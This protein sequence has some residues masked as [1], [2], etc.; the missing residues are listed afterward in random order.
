VRGHALVFA[1][2][3]AIAFACPVNAQQRTFG[4]YPCKHECDLHVAGYEWAKVRGID[5]KRLCI[6]GS[7]RSFVEGCFAYVHNPFRNA[8]KDDEG[9]PVGVSVVPP[10]GK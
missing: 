2:G 8:D 3:F 9:N 1:I 4:G 10:G 6:Y 5:D 7:S